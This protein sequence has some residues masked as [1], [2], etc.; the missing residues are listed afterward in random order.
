MLDGQR[1]VLAEEDNEND[2]KQLADTSYEAYQN[3]K[4]HPQ[5]VPYLEHMSTLKF[6]A[7]TNIGSRPSKRGN[8]KQL[9]FL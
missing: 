4:A 3:F 7:K 8:S 5:F 6:Y 1:T 2:A 9:N